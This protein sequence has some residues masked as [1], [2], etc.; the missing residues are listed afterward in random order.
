[1]AEITPIGEIIESTSVKIVAE[2]NEFLQPPP[3]G[4]LVKAKDAASSGWIYG[5]VSFGTTVSL[6]PGRQITR[7][8]TPDA[9]DEEVYRE[10]PQLRHTLR[11][12]FEAVLVGY[13]DAQ[14]RLHR[15]LPAQPPPL[16]YSAYRCTPGE[17]ARFTDDTGYFRLLLTYQGTLPPER[18][19]AAHMRQTYV[20]RDE[21]SE[22]LK[23]AAREVARL[24]KKDYD[25]LLSVLMSVEPGR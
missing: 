8:S 7:R 22:W 3:L 15:H 12:V 17:I 10:H 11:T 24:M 6:D 18:L 19:L 1:M 2:S 25:R 21:D 23:R 16:H 9:H 20:E 14:G 13:S 5:V 4:S